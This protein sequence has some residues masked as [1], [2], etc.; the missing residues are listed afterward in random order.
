M[1]RTPYDLI[2]FS[3]EDH[4]SF[5]TKKVDANDHIHHYIQVTIG[6]E[7]DFDITIAN[8][9]LRASGVILPSNTSHKL[10]GGEEWQWYLLVNPESLFGEM[11][12]RAFLPRKNAYVL[13]AHSVNQLRHIATE[14]LLTAACPEAYM[15]AFGRTREALGLQASGIDHA[16]DDRIVDVLSCIERSPLHRLTVKR[17]SERVYLSESRLSHLFKEE[18]GISLSSYILLQKMETA[19]HYIF[20]GHTMT[21]AALEAGFSSSSHFTRTVRDKLGMPPRAIVQ[22][23]RY[24]KVNSLHLPYSQ[25]RKGDDHG[26][27]SIFAGDEPR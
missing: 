4:I 13:D 14:S 26:A 7:H 27:H 11:L 17:L 9:P 5:L 22:N 8:Q 21:E 20:S 25:A 2:L 10:Y 12:K 23:S 16:L 24:M 3:C 19:F 15:K 6:L 18:V 1:I